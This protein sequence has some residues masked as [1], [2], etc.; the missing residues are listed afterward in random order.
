MFLRGGAPHVYVYLQKVI[1]CLLQGCHRVN[2]MSV[3]YRVNMGWINLTK[4]D[5]IW[6]NINNQFNRYP[7]WPVVYQV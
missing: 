4:I 2:I 5:K 3:K 7:S 6:S 1:L